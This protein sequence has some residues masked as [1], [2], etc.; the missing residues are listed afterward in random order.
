M[1]KEATSKGSSRASKQSISLPK[2]Q[3]AMKE[4]KKLK[5]TIFCGEAGG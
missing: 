1:V 5:A 2:V 4:I 3:M